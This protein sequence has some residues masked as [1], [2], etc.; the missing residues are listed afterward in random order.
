METANI[1]KELV[2]HLQRHKKLLELIDKHTAMI[3]ELQAEV[4]K[5]KTKK[6]PSKTVHR[7]I[8]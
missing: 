1:W 5:L 8:R 4:K 2:D 6:K 7:I 3:H